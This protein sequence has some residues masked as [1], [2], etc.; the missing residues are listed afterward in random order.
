ME[1]IYK[2]NYNKSIKYNKKYQ[3]NN[4]RLRWAKVAEK[5][6]LKITIIDH[7]S[8]NVEKPPKLKRSVN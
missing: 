3:K 1:Y 6:N 2:K 5:A 8:E 7:F 4:L